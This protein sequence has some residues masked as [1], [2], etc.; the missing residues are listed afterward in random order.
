MDCDPESLTILTQSEETSEQLEA[1]FELTEDLSSGW[2]EPYWP[3][4]NDD[5]HAVIGSNPSMP[6]NST[7]F[8]VFD[9]HIGVV[10]SVQRR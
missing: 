5:W 8:C 3:E 10:D 4:N 2:W 6:N 7:S 1:A 9:W